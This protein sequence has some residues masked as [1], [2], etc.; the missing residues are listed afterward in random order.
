MKRAHVLPV[1]LLLS[2]CGGGGGSG[3]PGPQPI[4]VNIPSTFA[5]DGSGRSNGYVSTSAGMFVGDL[6]SIANGQSGRAY[7]GFDLAGAGVPPTATIQGA[8]LSLQQAGGEG[9]PYTTLG[10]LL[11]DH[12]NL[13]AAIDVSDFAGNTILD[14]FGVLSTDTV[15]EVKSIEVGARVQA[16]LAAG[17]T[18]SDF[19]LRF[20]SSSD[21]DG[22]NDYVQFNDSEDYAP[23]GPKPVLKVVYLP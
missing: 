5:R 20:A 4:V 11:V 19:R 8:T 12:V 1:L 3:D 7:V 14:G 16:D 6:D 13:G 21:V 2:A 17:R 22:A 23:L 9:S 10:N 15:I 18:F